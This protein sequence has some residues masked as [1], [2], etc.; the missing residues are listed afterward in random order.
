MS[1]YYDSKFIVWYNGTWKI[2]KGFEVGLTLIL[3]EPKVISLC[4]STE[5]GQPAHLCSLTRLY[6]VGWP[7]SSSYLDIPKYDNK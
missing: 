1:Q 3:Q 5:P 2:S 4:A 6:A 7:T